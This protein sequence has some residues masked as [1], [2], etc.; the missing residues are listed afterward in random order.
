MRGAAAVLV[1]SRHSAKLFARDGVFIWAG[2]SMR[3]SGAHERPLAY[4]R[5]LVNSEAARLSQM[6]RY[7]GSRARSYILGLL[8]ARVTAQ[9]G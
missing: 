3:L 4:L 6:L 9:T 1:Q 7:L 5:P 8:V 2:L